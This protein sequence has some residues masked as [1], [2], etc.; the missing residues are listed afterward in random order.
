MGVSG[1]AV[2][3]ATSVSYSAMRLVVGDACGRLVSV[4]SVVGLEGLEVGELVA[5][6]WQPDRLSKQSSIPKRRYLGDI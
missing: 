2:G 5:W 6:F 3:K 1:T 4:D